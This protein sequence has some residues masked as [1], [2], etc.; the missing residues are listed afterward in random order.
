MRPAPT[1]V[2]IVYIDGNSTIRV[3]DTTFSNKQVQ[4]FSSSG[5]WRSIALG[6]FDVDGGGRSLPCAPGIH[7]TGSRHLRSVVARRHRSGPDH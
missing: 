6:D 5:N 7:R 2:E 4:W 3:I 1:P